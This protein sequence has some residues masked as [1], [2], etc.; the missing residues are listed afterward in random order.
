MPGHAAIALDGETVVHAN[1]FAMAVAVEPWRD[2]E[3]RV[4]AESGIGITGRRRPSL[5]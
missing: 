1:A 5:P 3:A 4:I 2:L